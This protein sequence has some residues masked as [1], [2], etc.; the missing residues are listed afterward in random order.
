MDPIKATRDYYNENAERWTALKNNSFHHQEQFKRFTKNIPSGANIIDIGC[1]GGIHVPLFMGIGRDLQ[2]TGIDISETFIEIAKT[3]YPQIDFREGNIADATTLPKTAFDGFWAAAVLMH[4]PYEQW[5]QMFDNI[6]NLT[7]SGAVGFICLP[8]ERPS[9][10]ENKRHF[11][12]LN[13]EEQIAEIQ[14]NNWA[15]IEKGIVDGFT[16]KGIWHWYLVRLP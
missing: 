6:K 2:Y 14:K 12:I 7:T 16:K 11:T 8:T 15:I 1:A 10:T 3:R 9:D 5:P 13:P 4:I